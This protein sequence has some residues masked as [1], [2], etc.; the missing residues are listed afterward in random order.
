M[1]DI[2]IR[3]M[4]IED[5]DD[6]YKLWTLTKGMGLNNLDDTKTGINIFLQR[7]PN[8]CFVATLHNKIIGTIITGHDG[9]RGYIYHTAVSENFRKKGI[10][11]KLVTSSLAALKNEGINK[12]ALVVFSN[13]NLGN[14]FGKNLDS[15]KEKILFTETKLLTKWKKSL[16]N[17]KLQTIN[18][19]LLVNIK[20]NIYI[21][22]IFCYN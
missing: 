9:R 21:L 12:V 14:F 10:G 8:T 5:Y 19:N 1:N 18:Q 6:I 2:Y 20:A 7:N 13:N 22:I 17:H 15:K 3:P 16:F 11:Q 4:S